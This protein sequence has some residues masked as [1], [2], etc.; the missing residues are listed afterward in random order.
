M[1]LKEGN[2]IMDI[3]KARCAECDRPMEVSRMVCLRCE[4]RLE[5]DFEVPAMA[6]LSME[7]QAFVIAFVRHHGSIKK[8]EGLFG[9]SYPTIKCWGPTADALVGNKQKG[10]EV[11]IPDGTLFTHQVP[12]DAEGRMCDREDAVRWETRTEIRARRVS[13]GRNAKKNQAPAQAEGG[14]VSADEVLKK[15]AE[16]DGDQLDKLAGLLSDRVLKQI[17]SDA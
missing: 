17:A 7:D 8:M 14:D 11:I 6:R 15:L 1:F 3:S 12:V 5:G 10:D 9:V 13:F 4:V 2:I 16:A